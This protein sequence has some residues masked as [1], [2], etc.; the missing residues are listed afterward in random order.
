[1]N[2]KQLLEE[3]ASCH[4][5]HR[6][7]VTHQI[8]IPSIIL[9]II[10]LLNSLSFFLI[11]LPFLAVAIALVVSIVWISLDRKWGL[12]TG[13]LTTSLA[14]SLGILQ[15]STSGLWLV[16][17]ALFVI[18]WGLQLWGH[19]VYEKKSP[20]FMDNFIHLLVGPVFVLKESF[21]K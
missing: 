18:G 13:I 16:G 15:Y 6:N 1:M 9:G 7:I 2:S 10:L 20:A 8:G 5:D 3:Y 14:V 17:I 4:K 21:S 19:K 11:E 12:L